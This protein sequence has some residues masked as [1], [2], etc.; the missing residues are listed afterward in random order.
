MANTTGKKFGGREKGTPNKEVSEKKLIEGNIDQ[1][2]MDLAELSPEK[3]INA[4]INLA[5]Y[6]LPKLK[7]IEVDNKNETYNMIN[8]G[9][10]VDPE[11]P[12]RVRDLIRFDDE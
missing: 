1:L 12:F 4:V 2:E 10:G 3:R 8:L 7:Q 6:V 11:K 5:S 9:S